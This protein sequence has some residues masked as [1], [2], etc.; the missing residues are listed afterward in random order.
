LRGGFVT[1]Q[2]DVVLVLGDIALAQFAAALV[3]PSNKLE[4]GRDKIEIASRF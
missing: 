3:R 1:T 4:Q 2:W